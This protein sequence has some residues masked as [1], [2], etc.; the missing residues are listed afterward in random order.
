VRE[1]GEDPKREVSD[2]GDTTSECS[3][4]IGQYPILPTGRGADYLEI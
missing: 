2:V 4:R 3:S 1:P